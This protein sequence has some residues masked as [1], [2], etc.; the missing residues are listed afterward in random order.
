[1][2]ANALRAYLAEL[3]MV[4]NPGIANLAKR[5][6]KAFA[7]PD[8]LPDYARRA[9]EILIRRLEEFTEEIGALER[10][11]QACPVGNEASQRLAAIPGVGM[12]TATAIAATV[13]DPNHFRS[14][15]SRPGSGSRLSSTPPAGGNGWAASPSRAIATFEGWS[16]L[17]R[18]PS[19]AMRRTR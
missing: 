9:L 18:H 19:C 7:D 12:I 17:V 11:L 8:G 6:E 1:M 10:E 4:A 2:A 16:W 14:G 15:S 13:T 3:G 5:V